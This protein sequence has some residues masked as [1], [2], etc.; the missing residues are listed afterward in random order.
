MADLSS[1]HYQKVLELMLDL[2]QKTDKAFLELRQDFGQAIQSSFD[3]V[4]FRKDTDS[5]VD[6]KFRIF[7]S[8]ALTAYGHPL[9]DLKDQTSEARR[10]IKALKEVSADHETNLSKSELNLKDVVDLIKDLD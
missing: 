8:H 9:A 7:E 4:R 10:D 3:P 2:E 6:E 1:A 5:Y